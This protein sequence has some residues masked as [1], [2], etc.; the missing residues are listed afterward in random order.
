MKNT[1]MLEVKNLTKRFG[2]LVGGFTAVDDVSFAMR[3]GEIVGLLGP[4][5][6]GKTTTIQMLLGV[7]EPTSGTVSYFGKTLKEHREEILEKV[8]F[9]STYTNLPWRLTVRENL[10]WIAQLYK[11]KNRKQRINEIIETFKLQDIEKKSIAQLS[12]GQKTRVNLAKSFINYPKILLLDEPTA[13]M[14]P[15]IAAYLRELIL[16]R[17]KE[18][19]M[20][21]IW[22]SHN[23]A[24]VE[25]MCDR[26][27]F[28]NKGKVIADD[29]PE[30]LA[31]TIENAHV[32]LM[33]RDGLQRAIAFA[34]E[35]GLTYQIDRRSIIVDVKERQIAPFLREIMEK[36]IRYDEISIEKP[37]LE[38]YFLEVANN[39]GT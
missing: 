4:N 21:I 6:A 11:M 5:G 2:P 12:A 16:E 28:I 34:K 32:E 39:E 13:S 9:S 14:D 36:G 8:N 29:T 19:N 10:T 20:S 7:L 35:K 38:D 18:H 30:K 22:T 15:D 27:V 17:R 31:K 33:I 37:T 1:I 26:V 24:E 25:E 23:M 3:E